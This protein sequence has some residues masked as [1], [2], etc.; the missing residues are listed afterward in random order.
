MPSAPA[1]RPHVQPC[2]V[3]TPSASSAE[4]PEQEGGREHAERDAAR[5]RVGAA[6]VEHVVAVERELHRQQRQR[7]RDRH[8]RVGEQVP[9][10]PVR[11]R[12][13]RARARRRRARRRRPSRRSRRRA[14]PRGTS[15]PRRA[16]RRS[17]ASSIRCPAVAVVRTDAMPGEPDDEQHRLGAVGGGLRRLVAKRRED[18]A[19]RVQDEQRAAATSRAPARPGRD[20]RVGALAHLVTISPSWQLVLRSARGRRRAAASGTLPSVQIVSL[21]LKYAANAAGDEA[22]PRRRRPG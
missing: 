16:G 14:R 10:A 22:A 12:A 15:R 9:R 21:R 20:A 19:R 1:A 8:G 13:S 11:A 4:R 3:R 2:T 6:A 5:A 18:G 17:P 7:E